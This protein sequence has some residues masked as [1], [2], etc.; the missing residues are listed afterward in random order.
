MYFDVKPYNPVEK[1]ELPN[2]EKYIDLE[3]ASEAFPLLFDFITDFVTNTIPDET[4]KNGPVIPKIYKDETNTELDP[5]FVHQLKRYVAFVKTL[6][7]DEPLYSFKLKENFEE[8]PEIMLKEFLKKIGNSI[9]YLYVPAIAKSALYRN[10]PELVNLC[11]EMFFNDSWAY[12]DM[13]V[14]NIDKTE[15]YDM[16]D[17][18]D[19]HKESQAKLCEF[20]R[21]TLETIKTNIQKTA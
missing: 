15:D 3:F 1:K 17:L 10:D 14:Y 16:K 4:R 11:K 18:S 20:V 2:N 9:T 19:L 13:N 21:S 5:E 6:R 8:L 12:L 7:S